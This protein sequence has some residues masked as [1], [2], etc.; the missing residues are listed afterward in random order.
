[1]KQQ[2]ANKVRTSSAHKSGTGDRHISS[3]FLDIQDAM[4]AVGKSTE[5]GARH[6]TDVDSTLSRRGLMQRKLFLMK[7]MLKNEKN[8]NQMMKDKIGT[9]GRDLHADNYTLRQLEGRRNKNWEEREL[10]QPS[11]S[12]KVQ[13]LPALLLERRKN[14]WMNDLECCKEANFSINSTLLNVLLPT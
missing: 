11:Q 8:A 7:M 2:V 13:S 9:L 1:M 12:Q 14:Q 4:R 3:K 10:V 6:I 5:Q